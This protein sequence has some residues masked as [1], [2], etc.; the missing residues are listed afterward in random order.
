MMEKVTSVTKGFVC[1][2]FFKIFNIM[3]FKDHFSSSEI[4]DQKSEENV[5]TVGERDD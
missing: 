2:D 3:P 1:C 4:K 5:T